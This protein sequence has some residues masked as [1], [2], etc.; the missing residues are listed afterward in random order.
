MQR[1]KDA[2]PDKSRSYRIGP[3]TPGPV[4]FTIAPSDLMRRARH[5]RAH[6]ADTAGAFRVRSGL[7][8]QARRRHYNP[9][10]AILQIRVPKMKR[11]EHAGGEAFEND[12]RPLHESKDELTSLGTADIDR[13]ATF[14]SVEVMIT[15]G[16]LGPGLPVLE[17]TECADRIDA[18]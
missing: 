4:G 8:E 6:G 14:A 13:D 9:L 1:C 12:I 5:R 7:S 18:F 3:R 17:R 10:V 16:A 2:R 11:I 15:D